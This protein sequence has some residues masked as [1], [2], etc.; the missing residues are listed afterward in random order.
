ME[1][2]LEGNLVF[3]TIYQNTSISTNGCM[4]D[5]YGNKFISN[6]RLDIYDSNSKTQFYVF[7]DPNA[8]SFSKN[9]GYWMNSN[10]EV[11]K[12]Y[13]IY[14]RVIGSTMTLMVIEISL[15]LKMQKL[16]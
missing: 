5:K 2:D 14:T 1:V 13:L 3:T 8:S 6:N 7:N 12:V 15:T 9:N 4:K 11:L 16:P 10:N